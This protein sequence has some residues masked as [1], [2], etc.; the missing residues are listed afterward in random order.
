MNRRQFLTQSAAASLLLHASSDIQLEAA[1]S[2]NRYAFNQQIPGPVLEARAGDTLRI[3]F[4]NALA[5]SSNLHF[6]GLHVPPTGIAD[7]SFLEVPPNESQTYELNLPTN[8]PSGLFWYHPH[9][10]GMVASQVSGGLAGAIIIRGQ[11]DDQPE[12][13]QTP[14]FLLIF[15]DPNLTPTP[16]QINQGREGPEILVNGALNPQFPLTA[17]GWIR[18]RLLNASVS[19]FYR[20]QLQQHTFQIVATD[21]GLLPSPTET[22]EILLLPGQ[23]IDAFVKG[24]RPPGT[25][26]LLNL[27]YNRLG[28]MQ[29]PNPTTQ[30]ATFEYTNAVESTWSLPTKLATVDPLPAPSITRQ[31]RFGAMAMGMSNPFTING[32]S[33]NPNRID[34][35]VK[36]N[37][38]EDWILTNQSMMDHPF[39]IHTNPFQIVNASPGWYDVALIPAGRSLHIRHQFTDFT[40]TAMYHC[41]ILDHEDLGMMGTIDIQPA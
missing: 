25:Y 38:I 34:T 23:R 13:Q 16:A 37:A 4:H 35:A 41:H 19:R 2:A 30:L 36:L 26:R 17:N 8:H 29:S 28:G 21:G 22:A 7:N 18:L 5:E 6:H 11:F 15:Q 12:I 10:H 20:L 39:H 1:P 32:R 40:G 33:F 3:Q 14:E 31:F 9:M 24:N 27:P